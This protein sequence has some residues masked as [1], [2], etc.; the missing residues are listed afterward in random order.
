ME[1]KEIGLA[2]TVFGVFL[3]AYE[4]FFSYCSRIVEGL[5]FFSFSPSQPGISI[6]LYSLA[7]IVFGLLVFFGSGG[8]EKESS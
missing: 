7:V 6:P 5:C 4:W 2:I 8:K 3:F 1:L